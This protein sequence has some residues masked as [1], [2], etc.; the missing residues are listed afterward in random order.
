MAG[1]DAVAE[2]TATD[3]S[4]QQRASITPEAI[5][6]L[7]AAASTE[8]GTIFKLAYIGGREIQAGGQSF[9]GEGGRE[10]AKWENALNELVY[11]GLVVAR[12]YK[13]QLFELTHTG[14]K[15]ADEL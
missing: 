12:G 3:V 11:A 13:D 8:E 1:A 5:T 9:G 14:W 7:K 2:Q 10:A 4:T 6:L 15:L